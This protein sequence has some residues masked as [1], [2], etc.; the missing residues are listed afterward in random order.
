MTNPQQTYCSYFDYDTPPGLSTQTVSY[1][2][3]ME[4]CRLN[5]LP[6]RDSGIMSVIIAVMLLSIFSMRHYRRFFAHTWRDLTN[7]RS[8]I[9]AFDDHTLN[10]TRIIVAL[11]LM[12]CM[13]EALL[14]ISVFPLVGTTISPTGA[15]P[16]M[17][18]LMLMCSLYVVA[19][20]SVYWIV[21]FVFTSRTL[22][23]QWISGFTSVQSFLA[24]TLLLPALSAIFY[25]GHAVLFATIGAICYIGWRIVFIVKG[26]R[27]FFHNYFSLVYFIL[28]LCSVEI[29]PLLLLY[30][31]STIICNYLN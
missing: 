21:G 4:P 22:R 19:Q 8:R 17:M 29:I 5:E 12:A 26:F 6:G 9:N 28:Y 10:E 13:G 18:A 25:P 24:L 23:A 27:I 20:Y 2:G 14:L 15:F 16:T 7:V 31:S 1:T 11:N 30:R 3:G